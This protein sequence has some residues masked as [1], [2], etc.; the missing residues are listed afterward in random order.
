[1]LC[2]HDVVRFSTGKGDCTMCSLILKITIHADC[3]V[4]LQQ[5]VTSLKKH[6]ALH[7]QSKNLHQPQ[8]VKK[9]A[10]AVLCYLDTIT[11]LN[12]SRLQLVP[13]LRYICC[14]KNLIQDLQKGKEGF[15]RSVG[16]GYAQNIAMSWLYS[17][18]L[19]SSSS[20]QAALHKVSL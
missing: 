7:R 19:A 9:L 11:S 6:R 14:V 3:F 10:D 13:V 12:S 17:S 5:A 4:K 8:Q 20:Q 2:N 1:M 18:K 15:D 16:V